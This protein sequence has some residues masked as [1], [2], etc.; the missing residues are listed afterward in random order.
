MFHKQEFLDK[1]TPEERLQLD[2]KVVA[3]RRLEYG[4]HIV[5]KGMQ[6]QIFDFSIESDN[7]FIRWSNGVCGLGLEG[8]DFAF[9]EYRGSVEYI[10]DNLLSSMVKAD[11]APCSSYTHLAQVIDALHKMVGDYEPSTDEHKEELQQALEHM[12]LLRG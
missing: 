5:S 1:L 10:L 7:V 11:D 6:G 9:I 2:K 3:I 8:E 12:R 4:N